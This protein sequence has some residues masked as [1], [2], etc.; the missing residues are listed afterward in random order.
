MSGISEGLGIIHRAGCQGP[1]YATAM[2]YATM[3]GRNPYFPLVADGKGGEVF[4]CRLC[5]MIEGQSPPPDAR[6]PG[7]PKGT[8]AIEEA[9]FDAVHDRLS[10]THGREPTN[11]ELQR[12]LDF[13]EHAVG[14]AHRRYHATPRE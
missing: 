5:G 7:R 14:N 9:V 8:L 13:G 6:R 11:S 1:S 2:P 3:Y 4:Q 10:E 12:E